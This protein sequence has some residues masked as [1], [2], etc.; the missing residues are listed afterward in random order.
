[1]RET[2]GTGNETHSAIYPLSLSKR[3]S[4]RCP[5][6]EKESTGRCGGRNLGKIGEE[7]R[8]REKAKGQTG[9]KKRAVN[10]DKWPNDHGGLTRIPFPRR[11]P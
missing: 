6:I 5:L 4:M 3:V 8:K 9:D 1:M 10:A 2:V 11:G 7:K